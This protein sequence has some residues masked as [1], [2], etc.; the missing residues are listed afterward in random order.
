MNRLAAVLALLA[1]PAAT[2]AAES[3]DDWIARQ[4]RTDEQVLA[5]AL[6]ET[7]GRSVGLL[8][9]SRTYI[10]FFLEPP[11]GFTFETEGQRSAFADFVRAESQT[12]LPG[13]Y[14][15]RISFEGAPPLYALSGG[16]WTGTTWRSIDLA[17]DFTVE[18]QR[19]WAGGSGYMYATLLTGA[20]PRLIVYGR[21]GEILREEVFDVSVVDFEQRAELAVQPFAQDGKPL[22]E[23]ISLNEYV[24]DSAAAWRAV[25]TSGPFNFRNQQ[26]RNDEE[27]RLKTVP[28]L[29]RES[30]IQALQ[31]QVQTSS[32]QQ[33]K[34]TLDEVDRARAQDRSNLPGHS[35]SPHEESP[36][37]RARGSGAAWPWLV[38]A[39]VLITIVTIAIKRRV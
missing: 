22:L 12:F 10:P 26:E 9:E 8:Q 31:S 1:S 39:A 11:S 14:L 3:L 20:P 15:F 34:G 13:G 23:M 2:L 32:E 5:Q 6:A 21:S 27:A 18:P 24:A 17:K 35:A 16:E 7:G 36:T 38:A 30:L 28:R 29:T 37:P 25:D 33:P 4:I 19:L